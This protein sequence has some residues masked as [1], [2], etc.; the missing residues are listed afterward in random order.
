MFTNLELID[1]EYAL[2]VT[3]STNKKLADANADPEMKERFLEPND[4]LQR[5]EIKVRELREKQSR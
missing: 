1:L 3:R 4:R 2:S 5:L